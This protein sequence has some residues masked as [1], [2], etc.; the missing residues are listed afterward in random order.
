MHTTGYQVVTITRH[1][2]SKIGRFSPGQLGARTVEQRLAWVFLSVLLH[3]QGL[4]LFAP[5]IYVFGM[6]F[7]MGT[8]S[9]DVIPIIKHRPALGF[10]YRSPELYA[11]VRPEMDADDSSIDAVGFCFVDFA[12]VIS[13]FFPLFCFLSIAENFLL[14]G[15][16]Y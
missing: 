16:G 14:I 12:L 3:R 13:T 7:Y 15:V 1:R 6:L 9:F 11:M 5:L 4:F 8:V 2:Y 10:I